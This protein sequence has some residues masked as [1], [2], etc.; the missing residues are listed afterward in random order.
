MS[1]NETAKLLLLGHD[2]TVCKNA[3]L[4]ELYDDILKN[5]RICES[6]EKNSNSTIRVRRLYTNENT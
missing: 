5:E 6:F 3:A 4:C 1:E 2:C